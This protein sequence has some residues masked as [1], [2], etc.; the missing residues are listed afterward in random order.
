MNLTVWL[1]GLET[2]GQLLVTVQRSSSD[3]LTIERERWLAVL[4]Q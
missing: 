3:H 2:G 4:Q 1:G